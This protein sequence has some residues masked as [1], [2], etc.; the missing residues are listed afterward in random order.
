MLFPTLQIRNLR[1]ESSRK[2][3]KVTQYLAK[4]GFQYWRSDFRAQAPHTLHNVGALT[5]FC[6]GG[7][8]KGLRDHLVHTLQTKG[9][10]RSERGKDCLRFYVI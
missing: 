10:W 6:P 5:E 4:P 8:P 7:G 1:P 3:L 2:Q 9:D